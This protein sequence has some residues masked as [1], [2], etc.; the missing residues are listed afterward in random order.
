V[1]SQQNVEWA[2][3]VAGAWTG[4]YTEAVEALLRTRLAPDFELHPLYLGQSYRGLEGMRQLWADIFE[5][6][7]DYRLE[8][9]EIVDL[10]E[11]VLVLARI[12]GRG[13]G[14]GVPIDQEV[15]VLWYFE[16]EK[17]VWAKSFLSKREAL[18]AAALRE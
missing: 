3:Q 9:G 8:I 15:A 7:T 13:V 14:S 4:R 2:R 6:W 12:L 10:G 5:T 16:G 18:A 17:A 11:H 1:T